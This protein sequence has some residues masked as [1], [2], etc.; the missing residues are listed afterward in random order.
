MLYSFQNVA[1]SFLF[2]YLPSFVDSFIQILNS[3]N[4]C[5]TD[6]GL[7]KE[8]IISLA[9][10]IECFPGVLRPHLMAIVTPVW[11]ILLKSVDLYL[12]CLFVC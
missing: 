3:S 2:P 5:N 6:P 1:Q 11:N 9:K 10:L 4:E 8:I 7:R 12:P